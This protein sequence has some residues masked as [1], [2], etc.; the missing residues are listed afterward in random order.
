MA[1]AK[2]IQFTS[3]ILGAI[4]ACLVLS[5]ALR[6]F[7][8]NLIH[9]FLVGA[10]ILCTVLLFVV[11]YKMYYKHKEFGYS[12]IGRRFW[13]FFLDILLIHLITHIVIMITLVS[14]GQLLSDFLGLYSKWFGERY[15][16]LKTEVF[17]LGVYCLYS[18]VCEVI[19]GS[20]IGKRTLQMRVY[21]AEGKTPNLIQAIGRNIVKFIVLAPFV[22]ILTYTYNYRLF[23]Y[24]SLIQLLLLLYLYPKCNSKR[25][26]LQDKISGFY[27]IDAAFGF[28]FSEKS[29]G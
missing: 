17:L 19:W 7:G 15:F 2:P 28:R 9:S 24:Q 20:T 29:N 6:L 14:K 13:A 10:I 27:I 25:S 21:N 16:V 12:S 4:A 8:F 1:K 23:S 5:S 26:Y 3:L 22:L 18:V 11:L